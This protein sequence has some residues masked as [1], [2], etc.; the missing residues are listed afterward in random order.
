LNGLFRGEQAGQ[1]NPLARP[2]VGFWLKYRSKF[3]NVFK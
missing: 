1:V 2:Y 3:I